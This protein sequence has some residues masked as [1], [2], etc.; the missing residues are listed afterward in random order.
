MISSKVADMTRMENYNMLTCSSRG[1][2]CC[3]QCGA[4]DVNTEYYSST[5]AFQSLIFNNKS[6]IK[7]KKKK[8]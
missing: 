7:L 8:Y 1:I 6:S 4:F 3:M 5:N 2:K